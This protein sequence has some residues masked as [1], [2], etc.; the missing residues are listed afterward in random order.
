MSDTAREKKHI[1]VVSQ[2]FY[3]E[4]FRINDMCTEWVRRGYKVTVLTGIPNY[5]YGKYYKG[6]GLFKKRRESYNGMDIIRIPLIA[7]GKGAV[8]MCLNYLS[9]VVSGF[10]WKC[11]TPLKCDMVFNFEVSPM[12]QVLVGVWYAQRRKIPCWLYVQ[13]LWP[14]NIEIVTGIHSPLVLKPIGRMVDYIYRRCDK[15]F[16]T[17]PSFVE[18]ISSRVPDRR[19]RVSYWPQYAEEF[20]RPTV[21]GTSGLIAPDSR[22]KIAFTGNVGQA[23]GLDI[24]PKAAAVMKARGDEA[25]FVIVGDGRSKAAL[26][27]E[28]AALGVENMFLLLPRQNAED[29]P[30]ILAECDAAFVSFMNSPLFA[31]TIPAKLQSYMACAMPILA[32]ATGETER[33]VRQAHCGVCCPIGD[34]EALCDAITEL[35]S[36]DKLCEYG[37]NAREYF[38]AHFD[39][40]KLLDRFDECV[41]AEITEE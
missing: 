37:A 29:I 17:S 12:T 5:P 32:C 2:Y 40:K 16:A 18:E 8:G 24:L 41:A 23:Q 22:F 21:R 13:D 25:L 6:Y 39:K 7:R 14:D 35:K 27:A 33:I 10:F 4:S 28:I 9:F 36:S 3:P 34:A 19:E 11:F 38:N 30:A 20:Y 26:E 31:N 1:L 15:I